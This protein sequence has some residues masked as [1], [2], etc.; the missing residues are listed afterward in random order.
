[1]KCTD[2]SKYCFNPKETGTWESLNSNKCIHNIL[3]PYTYA[4]NTYIWSI[5]RQTSVCALW[6]TVAAFQDPNSVWEEAN[7]KVKSDKQ[8]LSAALWQVSWKQCGRFHSKI[9][10]STACRPSWIEANH[11]G[12]SA[13]TLRGDAGSQGCEW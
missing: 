10:S 3:Y 4:P 2:T 11:Q 13:T 7:Q 5:C 6:E 1:M 9:S 12:H 8:S